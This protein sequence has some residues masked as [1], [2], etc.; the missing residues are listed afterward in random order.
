VILLIS[1]SQVARITGMHEPP[2]PTQLHVFCKHAWL[3][4]FSRKFY[5]NQHSLIIMQVRI[6]AKTGSRKRQDSRMNQA[7]PVTWTWKNILVLLQTGKPSR[8]LC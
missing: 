6:P 3:R 2:A 4:D 5:K 1:A 8:N 7:L